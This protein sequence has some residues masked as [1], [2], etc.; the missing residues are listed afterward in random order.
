MQKPTQTL[1]SVR[2]PGNTF[3]LNPKWARTLPFLIYCSWDIYRD[4]PPQFFFFKCQSWYWTPCCGPEVQKPT[5]TL[6]SVKDPGNTFDLKWERA[7]QSLVYFSWDIYGDPPS[8]QCFFFKYQ[9]WYL[10]LC[11]GLEVQKPTQALKS[12]KYPGNTFDLNP[13]C[14]RT[15]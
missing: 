14:A 6:K 7:L 1:T 10:T 12:D 4:S 11:C 15:L 9:S 5:Q 2:D 3:D 13:S 8:P